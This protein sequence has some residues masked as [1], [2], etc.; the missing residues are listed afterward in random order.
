MSETPAVIY[1]EADDEV[2]SVVRRLRAAEPG[3]VV[4]VAPGRSRAT[5][6]VVALRLLGR[7]AQADERELRLVGDALT[8]SLAAEAGVAAFATLEDARRADAAAPTIERQHAA[9]HVVRGAL[10]DDTAPTFA[11]APVTSPA[12]DEMTRTVPVV[13]PRPRSTIARPGPTRWRRLPLAAVGSIVALLIVVVVAG[14]TLLP[15]ATLTVT[16]RIIDIGPEPY[17]VVIENPERVEGIAEGTAQVVAT[18]TYTIQEPAT[19][20]VVLFNWNFVPVGVSAGT[21]VAAGE[22]AFETTDDI[23]V[24][25]GQLNAE[26]RIQAGEAVTAVVAAAVGPAAN[27]EAGAIDVVL[28]QDTAA[29]L[30]GFPNNPERLVINPEATAGGVDTTGPEIAQADVDL[31][32]ETLRADLA[33]QIADGAAEVDERIAV[34]AATQEPVIEGL[35]DLAGRRDEERVEIHGSQPWSIAVANER[36]VVERGV[37]QLRDDP[38]A[39][40][41]GHDLLADSVA[42]TIGEARVEGDALLVDVTAT[43]VAAVPVSPF[44]IRENARG[45]TAAEAEIVLASFGDA[46]VELWP[47]WV[48]TV[49]EVDWRVEVRIV[50]PEA[51]EP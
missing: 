30:R 34:A 14:A 28:S 21:L 32:L 44:A 9:V 19:G 36:E 45:R 20:S 38:L 50:D 13:R 39:V 5:S 10:T 33:G 8:R 11:A 16:P 51:L 47:G 3:P 18:D 49:P 46:R 48:T 25:P 26:G 22:Q 43:A 31:A 15:A 27:V 17:T 42:I 41:E 29:R 23:T 12:D 24:P 7:A 2:T 1:L 4:V 40:P 6:S 37:E 35:D